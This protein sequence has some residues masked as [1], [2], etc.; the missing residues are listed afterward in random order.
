MR[1]PLRCRRI[2]GIE[3]VTCPDC[4]GAQSGY[5]RWHWGSCESLRRNLRA[6]G[7]VRAEL[8]DKIYDVCAKADLRY[9]Y[10]PGTVEQ[11]T[12]FWHWPPSDTTSIATLCHLL[13]DA[14]ALLA[15][16]PARPASAA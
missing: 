1:I 14:R 6:E 15:R 12:Y 2:V 9:G 11:G 8:I 16:A 10:P 13:A 5:P 7:E 3:T 4:G